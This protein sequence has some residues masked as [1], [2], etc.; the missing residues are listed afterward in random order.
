M[1]KIKGLIAA[2]YTP[3]MADGSIN[4]E[5]IPGY[6][7]KLKT[8]G[9]KGVF[10]CGTTGEGMLMTVEERK[11]VADKWILE[12]DVE[13]RVIVHVGSPSAKQS[14]ELAMHA[15][16]IGAYAIG[17]M[18][19]V[20]LTPDGSE[21]LVSFCAE[22]ASGSPDLPFYYYYMPNVSGETV[23]IYEFLKQASK[24]IPNF[25][26]IKFTHN[27][28]MAMQLCMSLDEEKWDI[29]HGY[30]ELLLAGLALGAKGAVGSTYNFMAP[31]YIQ[32]IEDFENGDMEEARN[33]QRLSVQV[34]NIMSG[35]NGALVAGKSL[36][37]SFG[38]D[39][40]PCRLP[41]KNLSV[42]SKMSLENELMEIGFP[43]M[44]IPES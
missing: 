41:L 10:I 22:V 27:N 26:G 36:M 12:Q 3:M 32:M 16:Q 24:R 25:A 8:D 44:G 28:F 17:C 18:A 13:F 2:P 19:P 5:V 30:D 14:Q 7:D 43:G 15:Q 34:I 29:L 38:I 23:P 31:L 6:G 42:D 35:Y 1:K 39:C 33:K 20:F 9:L 21:E 4:T 37:K 11:A 40:G